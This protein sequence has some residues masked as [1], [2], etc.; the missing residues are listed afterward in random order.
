M[1]LVITMR[2]VAGG[3]QVTKWKRRFRALSK[4]SMCRNVWAYLE[5]DNQTGEVFMRYKHNCG[6]DCEFLKAVRGE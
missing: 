6:D 5:V 4:A 3:I 1:C 2:R